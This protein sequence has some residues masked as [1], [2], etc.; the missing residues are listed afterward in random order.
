MPRRHFMIIFLLP[1]LLWG[2]ENES[3]KLRFHH[4]SVTVGGGF[5]Q[6]YENTFNVGLAAGVAIQQHIIKAS[7]FSGTEIDLFSGSSAG[8]YLEYNLHYGREFQIESWMYIDGYVG[9]G[10]FGLRVPTSDG[11]GNTEFDS[12][13]GFPVEATLRFPIAHWFSIG[14]QLHHNFNSVAMATGLGIE[15]QFRFN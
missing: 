11:S 9:V 10:Y 15:F 1:I 6:D 8:D 2:Q 5:I 3:S 12:T 13:I 14:A 4:A 7:L